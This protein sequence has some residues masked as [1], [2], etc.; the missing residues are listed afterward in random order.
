MRGWLQDLQGLGD[1]LLQPVRYFTELAERTSLRPAGLAVALT[2]LLFSLTTLI[3]PPAGAPLP[4]PSGAWSIPSGVQAALMPLL[5]L[6]GCGACA[7]TGLLAGRVLGVIT[8]FRRVLALTA[9]ALLAPLWLMLWPTELAV[10]LGVLGP[11]L[12]GFPGLW[13]R[14]LA[15]ALTVC[16]Q[17]GLLSFVYWLGLRVMLREG[18]ALAVLS[19]LPALGWW[20]LVLR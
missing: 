4:A 10:S 5:I 19:L 1:A 13:V 16:H 14:D 17:L 11:D 9:P 12:P 3:S 15:P 6:V 18:F 8:G 7:G 2:S 20:A